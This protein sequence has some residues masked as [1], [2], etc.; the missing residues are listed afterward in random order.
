MSLQ[1]LSTITVH[2]RQNGGLL[3]MKCHIRNSIIKTKKLTSA[4]QVW[5][6]KHALRNLLVVLASL[7]P[8]SKKQTPYDEN[9]TPYDENV[10]FHYI[11]VIK[12]T[13]LAIKANSILNLAS[14]DQNKSE[15][16]TLNALNKECCI[17]FYYIGTS[18][19]RA[20][21]FLIVR[22][23]YPMV[24]KRLKRTFFYNDI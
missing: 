23:K 17:S 11:K 18:F 14:S 4:W 1:S 24:R 8:N 21:H 20:V 5:I 22:P 19:L 3:I 2:I 16:M 12:P 6:L 9:V 13:F 15:G 10:I 7:A